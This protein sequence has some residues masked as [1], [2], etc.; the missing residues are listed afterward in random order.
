[1]HILESCVVTWTRQIK[2]VLKADPDEA[3]KRGECP[4]P[5][6][7]LNFWTE[8]ATNLNLIHEQLHGDAI[9][10]VVKARCRARCCTPVALAVALWPC[11]GLAVALQCHSSGLCRHRGLLAH[12]PLPRL[13]DARGGCIPRFECKQ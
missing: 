1:V 13:L 10:K 3:L 6:T 11:C 12:A 7:E 4:G 2:T 8:R 9:Q 5:E